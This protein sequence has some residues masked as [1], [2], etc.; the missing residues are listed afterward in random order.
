MT[1]STIKRYRPSSYADPQLNLDLKVAYDQIYSLNDSAFFSLDTD[2]ALA[3]SSKTVTGTANRV[4][5][6]L[7][8]V[9]NV[10]ASLDTG[11]SPV[12]EWVVATPTPNAQGLIDI[13]VFAPTAPGNNTPI[14]STTPRLVRWIATGPRKQNAQ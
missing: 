9:A 4:D 13:A 12:N 2:Q 10:T 1:N 5:T 8:S 11:G 3:S 6:G 7:G 14:A